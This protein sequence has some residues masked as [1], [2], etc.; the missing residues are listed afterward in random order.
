ML[1][2]TGLRPEAGVA[3]RSQAR[4]EPVPARRSIERQPLRVCRTSLYVPL[5]ESMARTHAHSSTVTWDAL[6]SLLPLRWGV[7]VGWRACCGIASVHHLPRPLSYSSAIGPHSGTGSLSL[8]DRSA[9][10]ASVPGPVWLSA[11]GHRACLRVRRRAQPAH[12]LS[13]TAGR[14]RLSSHVC[15]STSLRYPG[16]ACGV[17]PLID[18]EARWVQFGQLL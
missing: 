17:A 13:T 8:G 5:L 11:T 16:A 12:P 3:D 15:H 6:S 9:I 10:P 1:S 7:K 18:R 4:C 2:R 14:S